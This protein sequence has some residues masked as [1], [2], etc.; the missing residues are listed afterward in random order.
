MTPA[1]KAALVKRIRAIKREDANQQELIEGRELGREIL[2]GGVAYKTR[3]PLNE[4]AGRPLRRALN[5]NNPHLE[6]E[7]GKLLRS[8]AGDVVFV[9][10]GNRSK[11]MDYAG[12]SGPAVVDARGHDQ[13]EKL[14][15][16]KDPTYI[17][18]GEGAKALAQG[19]KYILH[20]PTHVA[21]NP[22][23]M[24]HELG[25]AT[26]GRFGKILN[27]KAIRIP[28]NI[29]SGLPGLGAVILGKRIVESQ[30]ATNKQKA[31]RMAAVTGM[32]A[33]PSSVIVAEEARASLVGRRLMK[34]YLG[35]THG[36]KPLLS[37]LGTYVTAGL[38][39]VLGVGAYHTATLKRRAKQDK[40][41]A[42]YR[43]SPKY[44]SRRRHP[45]TGI[46]VYKYRKK[47]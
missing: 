8:K 33:L 44:I 37:A 1:K 3:V 45:I 40:L 23:V 35:R 39:P 14:V 28:A 24:A 9:P 16:R 17:P 19:K 27:A 38:A 43:K 4:W 25:H 46:Y 47:K 10:P 30:D 11:L 21:Q 31:N 5:A 6:A 42:L 7:T 41:K 22:A 34:K 32:A 15:Q 13:L 2:S 29:L 18:S 26:K 36:T 20:Y 12:Y